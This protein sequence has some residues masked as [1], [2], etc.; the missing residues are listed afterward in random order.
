MKFAKIVMAEMIIQGLEGAELLYGLSSAIME[1]FNLNRDQA[2]EA[3]NQANE[4]LKIERLTKTLPS[5]G[6]VNT[7]QSAEK[8]VGEPHI[9]VIKRD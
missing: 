7:N 5:G 8:P 2:I 4:E 6:V 3:M 9:Y 1:H